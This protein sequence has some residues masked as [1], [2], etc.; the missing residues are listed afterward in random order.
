MELKERLEQQIKDLQSFM[1]KQKVYVK[2]YQSEI[3]KN[4]DLIEDKAMKAK[5]GKMMSEAMNGNI[6][7]VQRIAKNIQKDFEI[8]NKE[9]AC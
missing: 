6:E 9:N 4:I 7:N 2:D 8:K 5:L 1:N 3:A